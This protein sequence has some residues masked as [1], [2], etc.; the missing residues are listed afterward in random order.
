M[1]YY[2]QGRFST[3]GR[4]YYCGAVGTDS[5]H[6]YRFDL[7]DGLGETVYHFDNL[8]AIQEVLP[9]RDEKKIFIITRLGTYDSGFYVYDISLDS[10]IYF[11]S[12]APQP[13]RIEVAPNGRYVYLTAGGTLNSMDF[14]EFSFAIFDIAANDFTEEVKIG[15]NVSFESYFPLDQFVVTPDGRYL[16]GGW[17]FE[18]RYLPVYDLVRKDTVCM[19]QYDQRYMG[20]I[21]CQVGL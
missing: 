3:D 7:D 17:L 18:P 8:G 11:R 14:P 2:R 10:I 16:V 21:E 1:G 19:L 20:N 4:R 15:D 6:A 13:A 9:S 5:Y 12:F